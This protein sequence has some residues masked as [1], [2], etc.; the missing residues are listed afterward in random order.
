MD[1]RVALV[2]GAS[3]GIGRAM[4]LGLARL[5]YKVILV[6]RSRDKLNE[7]A[8]EIAADPA[9]PSADVYPV[10]M[11][12]SEQVVEFCADVIGAY[13]RLD[14]LVNNA[15]AHFRGTLEASRDE[16]ARILETNLIGP[17]I[18]LRELT[19]MMQKQRSGHIFNIASRAGKNGFAET[20][21][22]SAT[23]FGLVGLSESLYRKLSA[24]GIRVTALC[25]GWVDTIMAREAG[26]PIPPEEM[27][28][29]DDLMKTIAWLL[30]LSPAVCVREVVLETATSLT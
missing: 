18:L 7:V 17:Y 28:Q 21:V 12:R 25:P 5:D 23:K 14:V 6:S 27:I 22:Y 24:D 30:S 1:T 13:P 26:A 9:L 29:P 15:G 8:A 10:D 19:P 2:T 11:N 4:A 3:R 20:G 16:F